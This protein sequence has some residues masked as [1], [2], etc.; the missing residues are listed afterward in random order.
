MNSAQYRQH[1]TV[2]SLFLDAGLDTFALSSFNGLASTSRDTR[3]QGPTAT[4]TKAATAKAR[5]LRGW[6]RPQLGRFASLYF[7]PAKLSRL[8]Q[9][10]LLLY[11]SRTPTGNFAWSKRAGIGDWLMFY[12][13]SII[14]EI[15]W[16]I[17]FSRVSVIVSSTGDFSDRHM[18][19]VITSML[20]NW[21]RKDRSFASSENTHSIRAR[22][23]N[24][25]AYIHYTTL[26]WYNIY[27]TELILEIAALTS[28]STTL[29]CTAQFYAR[30]P[31][32]IHRHNTF[33][34][35]SYFAI[36]KLFSPASTNYSNNFSFPAFIARR[37]ATP[38]LH[39][40][41]S[42]LAA[43]IKNGQKFHR[44]FTVLHIRS[45]YIRL[46]LTCI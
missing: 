32:T 22:T 24:Y 25:S 44:F 2:A 33:S 18:I 43:A 36:I 27:N 39:L 7:T 17:G 13:F 23:L 15:T 41:P 11:C 12:M 38:H 4:S 37:N 16:E 30:I 35:F 28:A 19:G 3:T 6:G 1:I 31:I 29:H 46:R 8:S 45:E 40:S 14:A 5:R 10:T 42:I 34:H 20:S 21:G 26:R 9:S